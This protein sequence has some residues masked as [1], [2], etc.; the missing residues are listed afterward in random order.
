MGQ[1]GGN[2]SCVFGQRDY[3]DEMD[4]RHA[5]QPAVPGIRD[6]PITSDRA[7]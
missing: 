4:R 2:Q 6:K 5:R 1:Q 3:S 7:D